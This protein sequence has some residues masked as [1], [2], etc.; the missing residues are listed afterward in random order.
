MNRTLF[1]ASGITGLLAMASAPVFAATEGTEGTSF[2][3]TP[4]VWGSNI[5]GSFSPSRGAPEAD[6]DADFG[7][8][9]QWDEGWGISGDARWGR[10]GVMA[11]YGFLGFSDN[12]DLAIG[13]TGFDVDTEIANL[14]G[15]YRIDNHP[16]MDVD[17]YAGGR[18]WNVDTSLD[19]APGASRDQ[20][21]ADLVVGARVKYQPG[22][23]WYFKGLGDAG[24]GDSDETWQVYAAGGYQFTQS[25]SAEL[26]YRML[27][28]DYEEDGFL[29][30]VT[31]DGLQAGVEFKF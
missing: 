16:D 21:W 15:Y 20:D 30:D 8:T 5:D 4:Y 9:D 12:A 6:A 2:G 31:H 25:V 14:S 7:D 10:F 24:A 13:S 18:W 22:P 28:V 1:A 23:N 11:E 19:V 3:I 27:S 26:G 29:Y 17:L